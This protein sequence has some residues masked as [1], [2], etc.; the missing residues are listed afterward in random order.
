MRA[1]G[2]DGHAWQHLGVLELAA[3]GGIPVAATFV[4]GGEQHLKVAA[5]GAQFLPQDLEEMMAIGRRDVAHDKKPTTDW[6][7]HGFAGSGQRTMCSPIA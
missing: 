3:N 7:R 2:V 5:G 6:A 1:E 4:T